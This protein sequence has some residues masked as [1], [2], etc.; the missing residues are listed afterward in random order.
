[1]QNLVIVSSVF[2][3]AAY[4]VA[5]Y[6][7]EPAVAV[8]TLGIWVGTA[9][10]GLGAAWLSRRDGEISRM[11]GNAVLSMTP[12]GIVGIVAQ[13]AGIG[14]DLAFVGFSAA[15]LTASA[16]VWLNPQTI[17][18][19]LTDDLEDQRRESKILAAVFLVS[20]FGL[21]AL[22]YPEGALSLAPLLATAALG[23]VGA[24]IWS[25]NEANSSALIAWIGLA[26]VSQVGAFRV[27][28][29][30]SIQSS[31]VLALNSIGFV[32]VGVLGVR[33]RFALIG[34]VG[35]MGALGVLIN[36]VFDLATHATIVLVAVAILAVLESERYLRKQ[37]GREYAEAFRII[38]WLAIS[39]P[40]ALA[41]VEMLDDLNFGLLLM[42]EGLVLLVWGF[43]SRVKRRALVGIVG[44]VTAITIGVVIPVVSGA[45]EGFGSGG[46]LIAGAVM[47]VLL[48]IAGSNISRY[49][50]SF[51]RHLD[52]VG[53][54]LEDWE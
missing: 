11:W 12:I 41:A 19:V 26:L 46:W 35:L 22:W 52:R 30:A 2:G 6:A 40:L 16:I 34:V 39:V 18:S 48:I 43:E 15:S 8:A 53:A 14:S 1:M 33:H 44:V 54:K 10:A 27:F 47:A 13:V 51:G 25:E 37:E 42:A 20:G 7:F 49:R 28:D 4:G 23:I 21:L 31:A 24:R 29:P 17:G 38:E 3:T 9:A 36:D 32:A 45:R 5:L 50:T